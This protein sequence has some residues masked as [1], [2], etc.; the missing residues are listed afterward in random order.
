MKKYTLNEM[1][2]PVPDNI[3]RR[4]IKSFLINR[5]PNCKKTISDIFNEEESDERTYNGIYIMIPAVQNPKLYRQMKSDPNLMNDLKQLGEKFGFNFGCG[6]GDFNTGDNK[7]ISFNFLPYRLKHHM[8]GGG[9]WDNLYLRWTKENP[10]QIARTG[11]RNR[12]HFYCYRLGRTLNIFKRVCMELGIKCDDKNLLETYLK[13]L[14]N[15]YCMNRADD[16]KRVDSHIM[17]DDDKK[18]FASDYDAAMSK[19]G[20]WGRYLFA[21]KYNGE[22]KIDPMDSEFEFPDSENLLDEIIDDNTDLDENST[23]EDV[24]KDLD[25]YCGVSSPAMCFE[26]IPPENILLLWDEYSEICD[27][28]GIKGK[29]YEKY[30]NL[31]KKGG[32]FTIEKLINKGNMIRESY[33]NLSNIKNRF[34]GKR[35]IY[36][37]YDP[38]DM[39]KKLYIKKRLNE[40]QG[41]D[42]YISQCTAEI[43]GSLL[44]DFKKI[45]ENIINGRRTTDSLKD[46]DYETT[47]VMRTEISLRNGKKAIFEYPVQ[48]I[49][50]FMKNMN[51]SNGYC[52]YVPFQL[53]DSLKHCRQ[54]SD[55]VWQV[56]RKLPDISTDKDWMEQPLF[57]IYIDLHS[58]VKNSEN[59]EKEEIDIAKF[60]DT[61]SHELM[62]S[63]SLFRE[64]AE[65]IIQKSSIRKSQSFTSE[66]DDLNSG[67]NFVK[68]YLSPNERKSYVI[69]LY[70][71]VKQNVLEYMQKEGE[72]PNTEILQE[73]IEDTYSWQHFDR[74]RKLLKKTDE[75][76]G[77]MI[78]CR[79]K[80]GRFLAA[81]HTPDKEADFREFKRMTGISSIDDFIKYM[82][83]TMKDLKLK[84]IKAAYKG[85]T[86]AI[87]EYNA[88]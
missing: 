14:Y 3:F 18:R 53:R 87:E 1:L 76:P 37:L 64:N 26:N 31:W 68:Y 21:F 56:G 9:N 11:F 20:N 71:S 67:L 38:Q 58:C 59:L 69:G 60:K 74:V 51:N 29:Y 55:T 52:S 36:R 73:F 12:G 5:Y 61:L 13:Y 32:I 43:T 40:S 81:Y 48:I 24:I 66:T 17:S 39:A 33:Q 85:Y 82:K 65:S 6:T 45:K 35:T 27:N 16:I 41:V 86:D 80:I 4:R 75:L 70:S 2:G 77:A 25:F 46:I 22:T 88:L 30:D 47:I 42:K 63:K 19:W 8:F 7:F 57:S 15:N 44:S 54:I 23:I 34:A 83:K 10:E 49:A 62:H 79:Q 50:Q 84:L 28:D 72:K 78:N